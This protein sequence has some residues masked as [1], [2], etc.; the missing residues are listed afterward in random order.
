MPRRRTIP[1][2][3]HFHAVRRILQAKNIS[4]GIIDLAGNPGTLWRLSRICPRL[5][6]FF[7]RIKTQLASVG[8][9]FADRLMQLQYGVLLLGV[10]DDATP[11]R[12]TERALL[13]LISPSSGLAVH[14]PRSHFSS[15]CAARQ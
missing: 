9:A 4:R 3:M 15:I 1:R 13:S 6:A 2:H 14:P 11:P 5:R 7:C 12:R 10:T 8:V